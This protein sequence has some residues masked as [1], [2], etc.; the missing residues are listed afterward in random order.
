MSSLKVFLLLVLGGGNLRIT[1]PGFLQ[2]SSAK[3][4]PYGELETGSI[5]LS[6]AAHELADRIF[7]GA[8]FAPINQKHR[9]RRKSAW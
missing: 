4:K 8:I 2:C 6:F 9:W 7:S 5:T 3:S 1:I